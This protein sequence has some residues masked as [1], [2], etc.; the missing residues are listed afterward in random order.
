LTFI[1][2]LIGFSVALAIGELSQSLGTLVAAR[3]AELAARSA[4]DDVVQ[5]WGF[6]RALTGV[7]C[8]ALLR[9]AV[10]RCCCDER[11]RLAGQYQDGP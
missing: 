10:V 3:A 2:G 5:H 6:V 1:A 8:V 7:R 11:A 4:A 9:G